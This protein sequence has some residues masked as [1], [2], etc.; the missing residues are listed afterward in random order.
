M[1]FQDPNTQTI[2]EEEEEE[3]EEDK[4]KLILIGLY[5]TCA[6]F[7]GVII[8]PV[9]KATKRTVETMINEKDCTH[10]VNCLWNACMECLKEC[11]HDGDV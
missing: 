11:W 5:K 4:R 10:P 6:S 8:S 2:K 3:E 7:R 9:F 1:A